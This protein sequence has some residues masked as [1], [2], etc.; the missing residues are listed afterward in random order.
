MDTIRRDPPMVNLLSPVSSKKSEEPANTRIVEGNLLVSS[1]GSLDDTADGACS[2][3]SGLRHCS[4][5]HFFG[6]PPTGQQPGSI[7]SQP[8]TT[9]ESPPPVVYHT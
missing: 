7:H 2:R 4:G 9:V 3:N 8:A 5:G 6:E 1:I